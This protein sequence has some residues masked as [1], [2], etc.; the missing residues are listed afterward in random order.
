M[1]DNKYFLDEEGV[2]SL[3]NIM[4]REFP[5]LDESDKVP[6][7]YLPSYVDDVVEIE[8][9]LKIIGVDDTDYSEEAMQGELM[10]FL[11]TISSSTYSKREGDDVMGVYYINY[12][13]LFVLKVMSEADGVTTETHYFSWEPITE[14]EGDNAVVV[15]PGSGDYGVVKSAAITNG[16]VSITQGVTASEWY[17]Y[18]KINTQDY[19][20]L[21][22][23]D[24]LS[25]Y[26][27]E[28][29][30][31]YLNKSLNKTYRWSGSQLVEVGGG[32]A[33]GETAET[34]FAGNKGKEVYDAV[35]TKNKNV[36][37]NVL[38]ITGLVIKNNGGTVLESPPKGWA[39]LPSIA[40]SGNNK[41]LNIEYG[42]KVDYSVTY[43]WAHNDNYK[44]PEAVSSDSS[45]KGQAKPLSGVSS[46]PITGT[47]VSTVKTITAKT[48]AK[49]IG[50][51]VSG[52]TVTPATGLDYA[53]STFN[54]V[55]KKRRYWG[56][57]EGHGDISKI[58]AADIL[59]LQEKDK[60]GN[61]SN[62]EL[63]ATDTTSIRKKT[64]N[65]T[66]SDTQSYL[67]AY[68]AAAGQVN[69]K[70]DLD[71]DAFW[72]YRDIDVTNELGVTIKYRVYMKRGT[73]GYV[74]KDVNFIPK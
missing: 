16:S 60:N 35:F 33:L 47:N 67:F 5:R 55:L 71:Q 15:Y 74:G 48:E 70:T 40:T 12:Y 34:A 32:V 49:K 45:W 72:S 26:A 56:I 18:N 63:T 19:Y 17:F 44:D 22:A 24:N 54:V 31:I 27:F 65:I 3:W 41:T 11:D 59:A 10:D 37:P 14:G 21:D 20:A 1:A 28:S 61:Y 50:L 62:T 46:N 29:G 52:T 36:A 9:R 69:I 2:K 38:T 43:K 68:E 13:G 39:A 53:T 30:K 51:M 7:R 58:T 64:I 23:D 4:N 57:V 42:M 6:S 73:G 8:D 25:K 66:I